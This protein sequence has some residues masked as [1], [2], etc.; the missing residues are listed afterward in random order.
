MSS[1]A[2]SL[3]FDPDDPYDAISYRKFQDE[4]E[5]FMRFIE[6]ITP[7]DLGRRIDDDENLE[8]IRSPEPYEKLGEKTEA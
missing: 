6:L 8:V 7:D 5:E 2:S 4:A 1:Q 3:T